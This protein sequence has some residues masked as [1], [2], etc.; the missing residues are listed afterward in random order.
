MSGETAARHAIFAAGIEHFQEKGRQSLYIEEW[1]VTV[2]WSP[3][4]MAEK[5]DLFRKARDRDMGMLCDV[6]IMKAEDEDGNKA[7]RKE[8]KQEMKRQLDPGIIDRIA[9]KILDVPD[10][11]DQAKN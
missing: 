10:E 5:G 3:L 1:D 11:E 4:N 7:F 2:Y 9:T 8:D 6:L